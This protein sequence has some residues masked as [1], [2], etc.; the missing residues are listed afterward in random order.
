ME[1]GDNIL[2]LKN[3]IKAWQGNKDE[4]FK[5]DNEDVVAFVYSSNLFRKVREAY[6]RE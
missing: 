5:T 3:G 4:I 1:I 6:L 2:F